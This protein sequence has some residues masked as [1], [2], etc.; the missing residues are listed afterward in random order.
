MPV[1]LANS[2][3]VCS[4]D[5]GSRFIGLGVEDFGYQVSAVDF[6]SGLLLSPL[7]SVSLRWHCTSNALLGVFAV[8]A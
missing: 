6:K 7:C 1:E 3:T 8:F 5:L 4:I 2:L